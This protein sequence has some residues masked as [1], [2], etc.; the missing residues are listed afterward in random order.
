MLLLKQYYSHQRET[1]RHDAEYSLP[2]GSTSNFV[3]YVHN[4]TPVLTGVVFIRSLFYKEN[5]ID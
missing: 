3:T 5:K 2:I 1:T 4:K